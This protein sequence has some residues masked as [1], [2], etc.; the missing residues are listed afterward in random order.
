MWLSIKHVIL[1]HHYPVV[2]FD[3]QRRIWAVSMPDPAHILRC[4]R[5]GSQSS[6]SFSSTITLSSSSISSEGYGRCL[7]PILPI[8]FAVVDVALNQAC[9]SPPPLPCRLLRSPAKDMGGV[10][11]RSCPYP[12]LW[13]MWLSIKHV[14]LLHHYPVVFFDL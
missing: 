7:C 10:Y 13:S 9:H 3:L 2:F 11:A 5:C 12:S 1:L 6:M 8:S 4:G 14:I